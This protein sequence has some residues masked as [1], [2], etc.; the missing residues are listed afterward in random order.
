MLLLARYAAISGTRIF[1]LDKIKGKFACFIV[2]KI[3]TQPEKWQHV[4][5]SSLVV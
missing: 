2:I 5:N 4:E 1:L 3:A